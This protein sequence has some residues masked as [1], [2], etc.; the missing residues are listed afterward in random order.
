MVVEMTMPKRIWLSD[1]ELLWFIVRCV[2]L[3]DDLHIPGWP[4]VLTALFL[5]QEGPKSVQWCL[6]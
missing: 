1:I 2:E 6:K 3:E 4:W 5:H